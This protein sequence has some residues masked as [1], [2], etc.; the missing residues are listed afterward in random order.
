MVYAYAVLRHAAIFTSLSRCCCYVIIRATGF[1]RAL[2]RENRIINETEYTPRYAQLTLISL[3]HD[4]AS[5]ADAAMLMLLQ[6]GAAPAS[7]GAARRA[8]ALRALIYAP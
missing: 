4:A 1:M 2:R 3:R 7:R 6:R 5:S 8:E